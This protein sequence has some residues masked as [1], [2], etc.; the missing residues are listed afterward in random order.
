MGH[1]RNSSIPDRSV[2]SFNYVIQITVV[3]KTSGAT[4]ETAERSLRV[5]QEP[6]EV[7]AYICNIEHYTVF[8]DCSE[9]ESSVE[10]KKIAT[11]NSVVV[12]ASTGNL[13][14]GAKFRGQ[15][16]FTALALE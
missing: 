10:S 12:S 11:P 5:K 13:N 4:D 9:R 2:R 14:A 15:K 3:P 1:L 6:S 16:P 8:A 7:N